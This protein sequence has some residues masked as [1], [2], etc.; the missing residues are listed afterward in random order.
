MPSVKQACFLQDA[1]IKSLPVSGIKTRAVN[2]VKS[3][4]LSLD[5]SGVSSQ[6]HFGERQAGYMQ[7]GIGRPEEQIQHESP[8]SE[9]RAEHSHIHKMALKTRANPHQMD[10]R[11]RHQPDA[12]CP[13]SVRHSCSHQ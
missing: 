13:L 2:L 4:V 5:A 11:E 1:Q 6:I 8:R 12:R 10:S 9:Y 3:D 7:I